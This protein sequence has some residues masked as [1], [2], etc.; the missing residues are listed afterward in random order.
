MPPRTNGWDRGKKIRRPRAIR[1]I[2][3]L[4]EDT[5]SSRDYFESFPHDPNQ[6]E[7]ACVGTGRNTDSLMEDA[8]RRKVEAIKNKAPYESI[9][10]VFD[11]DS[12]SS[13]QFNRAFDLA[14]NH[15]EITAC[16]SNEC[17]EL[18][19]LLHFC[20]QN[21]GI[22]REQIYQRVSDLLE[23]TYDKADPSVYA[24][25]M[26]HLETALQNAERLEFTNAEQGTEIDNPSTRVHHLVKHLRSLEPNRE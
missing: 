20:Y 22:A 3:I 12:F 2:L 26:P 18:W 8:I 9:W 5:K 13:Q 15:N 25:L 24:T 17:F 10:V 7:I 1:R 6:V 21:T 14:R 19:Y 4:C 23:K 11:K 16:W